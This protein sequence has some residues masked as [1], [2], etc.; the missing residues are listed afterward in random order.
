MIQAVTDK[1]ILVSIDYRDTDSRLFIKSA[2]D[3]W[4]WNKSKKVWVLPAT[5]DNLIHVQQME[6]GHAGLIAHIADKSKGLTVKPGIG[7]KLSAYLETATRTQPFD[8]QRQGLVLLASNA[9]MALH[10]EQGVMKHGRPFTPWD[11]SCR[12]TL[13]GG[14]WSFVRKPSS[15]PGL[16]KSKRIHTYQ[17][18]SR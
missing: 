18:F 5:L 16:K 15:A 10:W 8:H 1:E 9:R 14:R 12:K 17:I 6:P 4:R 7:N 3:G 11:I 13:N 2:P